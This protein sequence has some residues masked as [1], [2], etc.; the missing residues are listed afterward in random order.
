MLHW[1]TVV[2]VLSFG[3]ARDNDG[4]CSF[5][6]FSGHSESFVC[7]I[8]DVGIGSIPPNSSA[9]RLVPTAGQSR[10][11]LT[12]PSLPSLRTLEVDVTRTGA[13]SPNPFAR[14]SKLTQ[15]QLFHS[16]VSANAFRFVLAAGYFEGISD[17][18]KLF[19]PDL[20]LEDL[21][22]GAFRGLGSLRILE[23]HL[24]QLWRIR[25]GTFSE[26]CR[27]LSRLTLS[28]NRIAD[29]GL[30]SLS[31]LTGL[32]S[33]DLSGNRLSSLP[34]RSFDGLSNLVSVNLERNA[35]HFIYPSA[36]AGLGNLRELTLNYNRLRDPTSGD[37]TGLSRSSFDGL[38]SLETLEL[39]A[40]GITRVDFYEDEISRLR[41]LTQLDL[42]ENRISFLSADLFEDLSNLTDLN[43]SDNQLTTLDQKFLG[44][45]NRLSSLDLS[46]NP[47]RC[48][49]Q[50][51]WLTE[52]LRASD[53]ERQVIYGVDDT[54]CSEPG[55]GVGV[56]LTLHNNT[57]HECKGTFSS[58]DSVQ[59]PESTQTIRQP[60]TTPAD[61]NRHSTDPFLYNNKPTATQATHYV[62]KAIMT[63]PSTEI[64]SPST[65]ITS[66]YTEMT[67]LSAEMTS[68]SAEMTL[69]SAEM[70]SSSTEM[71]TSPSTEMTSPSA[72]IT[73]FSVEMTLPSVEMT[74][75]S[76]NRTS[77][78]TKITSSSTVTASDGTIITQH[79][80]QTTEVAEI[81]KPTTRIMLEAPTV[82][83]VTR[84]STILLG[85]LLRLPLTTVA[86]TDTEA[87]LTSTSEADDRRNS[88]A[89][90]TISW[91][92]DSPEAELADDTW[93]ADDR[94][95]APKH[96]HT[97]SSSS[98]L[99]YSLFVFMFIVYGSLR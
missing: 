56:T 30:V 20:G 40:N 34:E 42:S 86:T 24:N 84:N 92:D 82:E 71:M 51:L 13:L 78:S 5:H 58:I 48:D 37:V 54:K 53:G 27:L 4:Q 55:A 12:I 79:D 70:T 94:P 65:E 26:C 25:D 31:G 41:S 1:L 23:L 29:L 43:L 95:V 15:L 14:L 18:R 90:D 77:L 61:N 39:K 64:T 72:E 2:A 63:S 49:C 19:L 33:L 16:S 81:E 35:I 93:T 73:S 66:P 91:A 6:V 9:L 67:S 97:I 76:T 75:S 28:M 99:S 45:F 11:N 44:I 87:L 74:S 60:Q 80:F 96:L 85:L 8:T 17:L 57:E 36:F 21:P 98:S 50:L 89:G 88:Y 22:L 32:Q 10:L 68:F 38:T 62:T 46:L 69:I 7:P 52:W 3:A 83:S 59:L 47:W